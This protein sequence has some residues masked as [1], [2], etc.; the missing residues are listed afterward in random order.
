MSVSITLV[1]LTEN[2]ELIVSKVM[3]IFLFIDMLRLCV[4]ETL[5]KMLFCSDLLYVWGN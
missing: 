2:F 1:A 5:L 4:V 3:L